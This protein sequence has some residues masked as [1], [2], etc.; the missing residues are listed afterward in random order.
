MPRCHGNP[1]DGMV[2]ECDDDMLCLEESNQTC[3][4]CGNHFCDDHMDFLTQNC[5]HCL[6][7]YCGICNN[8]NY[9]ILHNTCMECGTNICNE[10]IVYDFNKDIIDWAEHPTKITCIRCSIKC[11]FDPKCHRIIK[12]NCK[13][14]NIGLCMFCNYSPTHRESIDKLGRYNTDI[15]CQQCAKTY[16]FACR[17]YG[18]ISYEDC[19]K[20]G[21]TC[22]YCDECWGDKHVC[23]DLCG[24]MTPGYPGGSLIAKLQID[25]KRDTEFAERLERAEDSLSLLDEQRIDLIH[26]LKRQNT[27]D[28]VLID[29]IDAKIDTCRTEIAQI[30]ELEDEYSTCIICRNWMTGRDDT[31]GARVMLKC[32]GASKGHLYHRRCIQEWYERCDERNQRRKCP[33][34]NCTD[35]EFLRPA[36]A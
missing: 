15:L 6:T 16:C 10:C 8:R 18:D 35:E 26:E 22:R 2:Y 30:Q 9:K 3:K 28:K 32:P 5:T 12:T 36:W 29:E 7:H 33:L 14:C 13:F 25:D 34:C 31:K 20:C 23:V 24:D 21:L 11:E 4:R 27:Y 17:K 1:D 19:H